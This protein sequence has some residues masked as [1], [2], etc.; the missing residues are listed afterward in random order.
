DLDISG[1]DS[2]QGI[3]AA[4]AVAGALQ[5]NL[6]PNITSSG[7]AARVLGGGGG[8]TASSKGL[9]AGTPL[10]T[11]L[12]INAESPIAIAAASLVREA[13]SALSIGRGSVIEGVF[14]QL[15]EVFHSRTTGLES[16][17]AVRSTNDGSHEDWFSDSP[18]LDAVFAS[19]GASV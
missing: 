14:S 7:S 1:S 15:E 6:V 5:P 17:L 18:R 19:L 16:S 10:D 8:G 2:R 13:V 9:G 11:T 3:N 4:Y 12:P